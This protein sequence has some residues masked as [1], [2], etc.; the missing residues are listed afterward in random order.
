MTPLHFKTHFPNSDV[1][2]IIL[3]MIESTSQ[4]VVISNTALTEEVMQPAHESTSLLIANCTSNSWEVI[5]KA[6]A[7]WKKLR[8]MVIK[9]CDTGDAFYQELSRSHSISSL[10]IRTLLVIAEICDVTEEGV[11]SI[12]RMTQLEELSIGSK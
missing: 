1:E 5:G 10:R 3:M 7:T 9:Q 4:S 11:C 8:T 6:L 2:Y 12:T